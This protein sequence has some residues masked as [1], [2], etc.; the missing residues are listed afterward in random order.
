VRDRVIAK[1]T[2]RRLLVT[3]ATGDT[4]IGVLVERDNHTLV[5]TDA[6]QVLAN[7]DHITADGLLYLDRARI[8]YLQQPT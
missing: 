1:L 7:G 3:L 6:A 4:F 5:F 2:R 8:A